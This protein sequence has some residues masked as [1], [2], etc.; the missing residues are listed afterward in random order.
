MKYRSMQV[1]SV[2]QIAG[3]EGG[4]GRPAHLSKPS[5]LGRRGSYRQLHPDEPETSLFSDI[6]K[7]SE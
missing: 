2:E 7:H 6:T 3:K 5:M 1:R 4:P